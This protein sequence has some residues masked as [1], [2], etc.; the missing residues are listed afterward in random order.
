ML[1]ALGFLTALA[2]LPLSAAE[3]AGDVVPANDPVA[4]LVARVMPISAWG[5][6]QRK[7]RSVRLP[8]WLVPR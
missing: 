7:P 3:G 4:V 1:C 5:S 6:T 2:A 8:D